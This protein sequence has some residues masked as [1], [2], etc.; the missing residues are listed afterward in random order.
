[1]A[2]AGVGEPD[3]SERRLD[4]GAFL[5]LA[6][7]DRLPTVELRLRVAA[8]RALD[9]VCVRLREREVLAADGNLDLRPLVGRYPARLRLECPAFA[10]QHLRPFGQHERLEVEVA[11]HLVAL[12]A[13]HGVIP[14]AR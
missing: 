5:E 12:V 7:V 10:S 6:E 1:M 9:E 8:V 11:V 2:L 4:L 14:S 13:A 3:L